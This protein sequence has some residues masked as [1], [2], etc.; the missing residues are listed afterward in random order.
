MQHIIATLE[1]ELIVKDII[2]AA[3]LEAAGRARER[4][5]ETRNDSSVE[6][7][8][9]IYNCLQHPTRRS[10]R[11]DILHEYTGAQ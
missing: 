6:V 4:A 3:C 8:F 10:S 1:V 11:G 9:P 5:S 2:D 7:R